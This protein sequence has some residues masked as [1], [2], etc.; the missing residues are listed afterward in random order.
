MSSRGCKKGI[1]LTPSVIRILN[2][3]T[4]E[5]HTRRGN[6]RLRSSPDSA[7]FHQKEPELMT[8]MVVPLAHSS[9][10]KCAARHPTYLFLS[11]PDPHKDSYG[12]D[13]SWIL[14]RRWRRR[15]GTTQ[16][17]KNYSSYEEE[18]EEKNNHTTR[19]CN[20]FELVETWPMRMSFLHQASGL[21]TAP[22]CRR[23]NYKS[24]L[25]KGKWRASDGVKSRTVSPWNSQT[26][27]WIGM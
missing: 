23:D 20:L 6:E 26:G 2:P 7:I 10:D 9:S 21:F 19:A 17:H 22:K 8:K 25:T 27:Q 18:K 5:R 11:K 3:W 1:V 15:G 14:K 16:L 4:G 24:E 13:A 12:Y